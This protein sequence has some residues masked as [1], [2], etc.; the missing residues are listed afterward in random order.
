M[1]IKPW[2][3]FEILTW[4]D[5]YQVKRLT[6]V[7]GQAISLQRHVHRSETWKIVQGE[8]EVHLDGRV[9]RVRQ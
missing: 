2:G 5:L 4:G 9:F 7:P 1:C 3:N 6:I 8:G